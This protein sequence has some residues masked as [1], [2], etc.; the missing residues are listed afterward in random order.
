MRES[1]A[2]RLLVCRLLV[3]VLLAAPILAVPA[4]VGAQSRPQ[5]QA[6]PH[7]FPE[8]TKL[9]AE[10]R[11]LADDEFAVDQQAAFMHFATKFTESMIAGM[12]IGGLTM[13]R[14]VGGVPATM[15]GTAAGALIASWLYMDVASRSYVVR[16]VR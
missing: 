6:W 2:C 11:Y 16:E 13:Y 5:A 12:V 9:P 8:P 1:V 7:T 15:A 4:T 10:S 14:L 3:C